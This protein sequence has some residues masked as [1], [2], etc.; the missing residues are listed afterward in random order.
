MNSSEISSVK[1]DEYTNNIKTI[2]NKKFDNN[3]V[4]KKVLEE[5]LIEKKRKLL[6]NGLKKIDSDKFGELLSNP[7]NLV[8]LIV[9]KNL[10]DEIIDEK[11]FKRENFKRKRI[12]S[13]KS[14]LYQFE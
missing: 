9:L 12:Q 14:L 8:E 11:L 5:E 3:T 10:N 7:E 4:P 13:G 6:K 1:N 2:R